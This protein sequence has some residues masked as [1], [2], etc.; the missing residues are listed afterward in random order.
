MYEAVNPGIG[1]L[2][3]RDFGIEKKSGIPGLQSL[4]TE[5]YDNP[6]QANFMQI[7][8]NSFAES[9]YVRND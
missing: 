7:E 8:G 1:W 5:P 6:M 3:S 2:Q 9:S 4:A